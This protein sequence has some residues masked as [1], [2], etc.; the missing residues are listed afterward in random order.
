MA[1]QYIGLGGQKCATVD[2]AEV[3]VRQLNVLVSSLDQATTASPPALESISTT[4]CALRSSQLLQFLTRHAD[5][6]SESAAQALRKAALK[7]GSLVTAHPTRAAHLTAGF[8]LALE[9][10]EQGGWAAEDGLLRYGQDWLSAGVTYLTVTSGQ[11][12][13]SASTAGQQV[14]ADAAVL[15]PLLALVTEYI[16]SPAAASRPEFARAVVTPNLPKVAG[17]LVASVEAIVKRSNGVV[18]AEDEAS[19]VSCRSVKVSSEVAC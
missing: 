1:F 12:P 14:K 11:A 4:L 2:P 17:V 3:Y 10:A 9:I 15:R 13:P 16:L 19:L 7:A 5:A 18:N 8:S 6:G